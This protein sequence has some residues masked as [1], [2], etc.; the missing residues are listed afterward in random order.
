MDKKNLQFKKIKYIIV[1]VILVSIFLLLGYTVSRA[2]INKSVFEKEIL[3][4]ANKNEEKI[5]TINNITLF[6]SADSDSEVKQNSTLGINN[7]YQY[8]DIAIFLNPLPE[9]LTYKNTL[10]E[11]YLDNLKFV[12]Q[13]EVGTPNLYYKN[14]NDF[15]TSKHSEENKIEDSLHF[16]VT[17]ED[18]ADLST[19]I[20]YNNCANPITLSYVNNNIKK[21][22]SLPDP[23][24]QIAYDG[25]LLKKCAVTLSSISCSISFDIHI[26]NN[27]DQQFICPI[28]LEIPL[29][30][31]DN[32]TIYDGKVLLKDATN[33]TFY[34]YN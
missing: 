18:T 30:L 1:L 34:R 12:K 10:K 28:Y 27:L 19:P 17:S 32:S 13:P 21:D 20:L 31:K 33:Y 11:V 9:K 22:Y 16:T 3:E 24:S 8:T 15:A 4:L 7:L 6:S 23:F 25:S 26:T 29:E 14:L 2:Y 5:F